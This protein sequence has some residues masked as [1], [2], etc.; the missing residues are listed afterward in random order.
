MIQWYHN[1][2]DHS[3]SHEIL[4]VHVGDF[5]VQTMKRNLKGGKVQFFTVS[6]DASLGNFIVFMWSGDDGK[7]SEI[8]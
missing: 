3:M 7:Y 8:S 5:F 6:M 2:I 4:D 1:V